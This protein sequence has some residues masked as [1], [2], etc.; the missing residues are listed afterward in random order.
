[1]PDRET[2]LKILDLA[3]WAPSGDN[4]Q[5]WRFEIVAD[6]RIAIHGFD[7][8]E[9]VLYDYEGHPSHMAH[10]A[11][12]ETLR[13]AAT[14]FGLDASWTLRPDTGDVHPVYDVALRQQPEPALDPLF[15]HIEPR[16]VQRRPMRTTPLTT[17]Q[18]H[19]LIHA[20]GAGYEVQFFEPFAERLK[21]ARLLW[22]NAYI[23]LTCPEAFEVHREIIEWGARY[24]KDRVP[25]RAVGVDPAT[26]K[27]MKWVMRSWPRVE[28]FNRYL[29]G[30]VPPR[31]QLDF[32][33]ALAC[34][35]HVLL[36]PREPLVKLAD[37]VAAGV[38]L[39][40]LWLTATS[41]GLHL[42][43]EMTPVIFRWYSR[44]R[45]PLS[46]VAGINERARALAGDFEALA[47]ARESDPFAFFCRVGVSSVPTSRSHRLS[48][49]ELMAEGAS[50]QP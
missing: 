41:V 45:K 29:M 24:S 37:Y 38:A 22:D 19:A 15:P 23:R 44:S 3:R 5:P 1:M 7:T 8:R 21:V 39:Q 26:A 48:L 34:A 28:F 16:V 43:P 12:L 42:Q 18:R 25:E 32:L 2:L 6:G 13:I 36:R 31:V 27:L 20:P 50:A 14:S 11:L 47:G 17:A 40:R 9:H 10:G 30:T 33:P 46:R 49:S 4:T 35:A